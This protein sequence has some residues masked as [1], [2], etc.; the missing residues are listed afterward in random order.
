MVDAREG[1]EIRRCIDRVRVCSIP[2]EIP[3][4]KALIITDVLVSAPAQEHAA[5]TPESRSIRRVDV[6]GVA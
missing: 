1:L 5:D 3:P 6:D 4:P 2:L